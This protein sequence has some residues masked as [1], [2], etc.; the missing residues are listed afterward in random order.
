MLTISDENRKMYYTN[1]KGM[2]GETITNLAIKEYT[3][4]LNKSRQE[5]SLL[6]SSTGTLNMN[7]TG[8][9]V[10]KNTFFGGEHR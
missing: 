7:K 1:D 8:V 6:V 2:F 10:K 3:T 9:P 4:E 5:G